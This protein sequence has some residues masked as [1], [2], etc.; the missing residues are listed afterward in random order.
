M[1][2]LDLPGRIHNLLLDNEVET[3]GDVIF[4]LELGD[5]VILNFRGLGE[6]ALVTI[7]EAW[8]RL[9]KNARQKRRRKPKPQKMKKRWLSP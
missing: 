8:Q 5:D 7:K 3:V 2:E 1:D 9:R 4:N 6:A